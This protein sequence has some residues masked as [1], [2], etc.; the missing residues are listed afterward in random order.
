MLRWAV[1][2]IDAGQATCRGQVRELELSG[3]ENW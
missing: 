2:Q 3:L 1:P